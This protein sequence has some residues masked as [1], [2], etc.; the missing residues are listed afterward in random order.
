VP[1][2]YLCGQSCVA[3]LANVSV[4]EVIKILGTDK[5]TNKQNLIKALDYYGIKYAPNSIKYDS[6]TSL[7]ELCI[8]R[9]ILPGYSHWGVYFKGVYFDPEFGVLNEC[10]PNAKIFQV[11][12]ICP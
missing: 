4:D 10:P 8:I 9:M 3:M 6:E 7:P 2:G 11:W 5:G 12:E 1:T